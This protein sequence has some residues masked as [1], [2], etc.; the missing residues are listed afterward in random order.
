MNAGIG[1]NRFE[2]WMER[3]VKRGHTALTLEGSIEFNPY[4]GVK[5]E[6]VMMG[7]L[8][9]MML[10]NPGFAPMLLEKEEQLIRALI[11]PE[12]SRC[13]KLGRCSSQL[14]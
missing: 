5:S 13:S 11:N 2:L 9:M 6:P 14:P 12:M 10:C 3:V 1:P 7:V 4:R 8:G